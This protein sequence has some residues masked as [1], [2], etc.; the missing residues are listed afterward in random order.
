M[1]REIYKNYPIGSKVQLVER[2]L[3][4]GL[5]NDPDRAITRNTQPGRCCSQGCTVPGTPV[6][7]DLPEIPSKRDNAG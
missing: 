5:E 7:V 1:K 6:M 4:R 3:D 2:L